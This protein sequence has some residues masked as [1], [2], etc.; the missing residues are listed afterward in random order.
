MSAGKTAAYDGNIT[1]Y[2]FERC[3]APEMANHPAFVVGETIYSFAQIH[4]RTNR[5][6]NLLKAMKVAVGDRVMMGVIDGPDFPAVFLG[7]IRMGAVAVAINTYLKP[8]DYEYYVNDSGAKVLFIDHSLV[9]IIEEIRANLTN[10]QRIVVSGRKVE[11]YPFLDDL[12]AEHS[13]AAEV[14]PASGDD[15]AFL[16]YSSGSTGA[17]KGVVHT[18]AHIY[19]ATELFGLGIQGVRAGDIIQCPP[20]MFFA[21][22]LGN[23]VYFPLRA[24]ATVIVNPE[25]ATPARIW[26]LWLKHEPT[27]VMSVPTLYAGMLKIAETEIGQE[28]TR[29]ALR[30][31]RYGVSGGEGL[32]APLYERWQEFAGLEILDGVGTT[33]MTHMFILN[34]PGRSVPGS[35]GRVVDGYR[36]VVVDEDG[37]ELPTGEVGNLLVC[38]PS[39]MVEYWNK[40]EKTAAT[41]RDGGVLTGD[42]ARFDEDGN[43]YLVGRSDD[44]LRVGG[45]WVSPLEV[46]TALTRHPAVL[47]CAVIGFPDENSMIK[48]KAFVVLGDKTSANQDRMEQELKE[49]CR[50]QLAHIKCPRWIVILPELPKA[51]TGKIQRFRLR[52]AESL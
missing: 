40:P 51:T 33:E 45:V 50:S 15:V 32:P 14:H 20:K 3:L 34:H 1:N 35:C 24:G 19:W 49:F 27:I 9:P 52:Q 8:T 25:P 29:R 46:E 44:M 36:A 16:L 18:H 6:A 47:E 30:R 22:G 42:K 4:E 23:Q 7:A 11:G 2:L 26:D 31:L 43:I 5:V 13:A 38:G 28:R 21:F 37:R 17:P 39:A 12:M 48:P 41:M 10:V